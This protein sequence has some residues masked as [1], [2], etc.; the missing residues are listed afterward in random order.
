MPF[1][2]DK[3]E[4]TVRLLPP[5]PFLRLFFNCLTGAIPLIAPAYHLVKKPNGFELPPSGVKGKVA[6]K[7]QQNV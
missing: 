5:P 3:K 1:P 2:I 6:M 7:N 4:L